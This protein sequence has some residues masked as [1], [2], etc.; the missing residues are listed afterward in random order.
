MTWAEID[1]SSE[2]WV[3][4]PSRHKTSHRGRARLVAI[5]PRAQAVLMKY[6]G[7]PSD[8]PIFSPLEAEAKRLPEVQFSRR[9][10]A[11]RDAYDA[12]S[13][14]FAIRRACKRAFPV[15][16]GLG[17]KDKRDWVQSYQWAPNQLR[18]AAA[19]EIR[20]EFGLDAAGAVLGHADV[21]TTQ[22][23]AEREKEL[24]IRVARQVG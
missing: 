12:N 5:G 14:G 6:R 7:R 17:E 9:S 18:H 1:T 4:R 24:A 19:T 20:R 21:T 23:Y 13:Y 2:V 3:Y 10:R 16:A 15:P 11:P 8:I 22:I